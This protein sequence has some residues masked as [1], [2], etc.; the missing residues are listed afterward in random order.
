[1]GDVVYAVGGFD[2]QETTRVV[3]M[4][5]VRMDSWQQLPPLSTQRLGLGVVAM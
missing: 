5:D 3:E 4:Y 2:G 1:M